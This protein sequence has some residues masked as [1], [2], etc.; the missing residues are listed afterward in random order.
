MAIFFSSCFH[1]ALTHVICIYCDRADLRTHED[2][3]K[4]VIN[5]CFRIEQIKSEGQNSK[6]GQSFGPTLMFI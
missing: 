4:T 6:L 3:F 2:R 1:F 5:V